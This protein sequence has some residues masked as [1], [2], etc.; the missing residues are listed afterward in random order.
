MRIV[1][2]LAAAAAATVLLV[3]CSSASQ[4]TSGSP[5]P[6]AVQSADAD[7]TQQFLDRHGLAGQT[8]EQIVDKLDR[9]LEDRTAGPVGSVRPDQLV[10]ADDQGE[11]SLPINDGFY[12]A[13]APYV[14]R[15]H[16]CFNHNLATCQGELVEQE[17]QVTITADDGRTLV[18]GPLTSFANGFIGVWLPKNVQGQITV[19]HDGKSATAPLSTGA[20][21]PTCVTTLQ[22]A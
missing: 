22:L 19:E 10:L 12:L 21:D 2:T 6:Q 5:A 13:F 17:M 7:A 16:E 3:G 8:V 1:T 9:T 4:S 20:E 11:V 18:N 14:N 15:T